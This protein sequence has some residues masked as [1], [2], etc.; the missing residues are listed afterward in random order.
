MNMNGTFNGLA[1]R[2]ITS[3]ATETDR[4][5]VTRTSFRVIGREPKL[6]QILQLNAPA[7]LVLSSQ[8]IQGKIVRYIADVRSGYEITIESRKRH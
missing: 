6:E 2:Q 3:P 7:L 8:E 4:A 5:G 1:L